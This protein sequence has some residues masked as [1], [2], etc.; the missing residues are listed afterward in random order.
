MAYSIS[1]SVRWCWFLYKLKECIGN[2]TKVAFIH[3]LERYHIQISLSE[4]FP[5]SYSGF[6][7][8]SVYIE[9]Q[10]FVGRGVNVEVL[11]KNTSRCY[12]MYQ[13]EQK[14]ASL[15]FVIDNA[16]RCNKRKYLDD[17]GHEKWEGLYS[18]EPI[19]IYWTLVFL[20]KLDF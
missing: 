10:I 4:V 20:M 19:Q 9:Y 17:L 7:S 13:F 5:Y 16:R 2:G 11:L 6:G 15:Y 18:L 12:I 8:E 14:L 1:N 3:N